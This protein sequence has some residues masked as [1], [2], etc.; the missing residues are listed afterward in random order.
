M[1]FSCLNECA[2][3]IFYLY[4][5]LSGSLHKS[6]FPLIDKILAFY[7]SFDT[8]SICIPDIISQKIIEFITHSTRD[9]ILHLKALIDYLLVSRNPVKEFD[10]EGLGNS[11]LSK[12]TSKG[13]TT[14]ALGRLASVS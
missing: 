8:L 14:M 1:L 9:Y 5:F 2:Y 6:F 11:A 10:I 4:S 3:S 7:I 12:V 13:T